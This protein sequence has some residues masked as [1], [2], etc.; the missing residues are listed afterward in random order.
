MTLV[1]RHIIDVWDRKNAFLDSD[2]SEE[3]CF[4]FSASYDLT[5]QS[6]AR[7]KIVK[8]NRVTPP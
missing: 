6:Y 7:S 8:I 3:Y 2:E 4:K 5:T 1:N